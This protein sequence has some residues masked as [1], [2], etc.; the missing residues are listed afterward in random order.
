MKYKQDMYVRSAAC[1]WMLQNGETI[2]WK[3]QFLVKK[4]LLNLQVMLVKNNYNI[5]SWQSEFEIEF[6]VTHF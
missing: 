4:C 5:W 6:D 3:L 1:S 2:S